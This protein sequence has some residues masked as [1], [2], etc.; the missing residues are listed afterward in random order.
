[1][2]HVSPDTATFHII[3]D[4]LAPDVDHLTKWPI[5]L[6]LIIIV[7]LSALLW[8]GIILGISALI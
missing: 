1:M 4:S 8:T 7:G 2:M 5:W 6:R 3:D